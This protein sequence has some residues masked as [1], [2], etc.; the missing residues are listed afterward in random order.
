[1]KRL[2]VIFVLSLAVL[3]AFAQKQE[4]AYV[5]KANSL[6]KDS[7]YTQ[8]EVL[9]RKALDINSG[10]VEAH[11]N[12]GNNLYA[13][14]KYD[15][16]IKEYETAARLEKDKEKL[17]HIY[18]N[19]GVSYQKQEK[20]GECIEAYKKALKNNP[21]DTDTKH[22]LTLAL[23]MLQQQQQQQQQQ[24]NQDENKDDRKQEQ[25]QNQ[26]NSKDKEDRK[27]QDRE[28]EQNPS[29]RQQQQQQQEMSRENAE[30]LLNSVMQDEKDVQDKVQKMMNSQ[31]VRDLE[32]NW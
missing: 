12:L 28:Q 10:S 15:E 27:D 13:G 20:Y 5:R 25:Q 2:Y 29:D 26:N 24:Q 17:G 30:K 8:S 23:R 6:Y 16:A 1:M 9:Y 19:M 11:Y 22:N 14:G 7:M 21:G 31:S 18:H 4:R 3:S 32:K